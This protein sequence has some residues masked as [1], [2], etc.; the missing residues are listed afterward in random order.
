MPDDDDAFARCRDVL[1][2]NFSIVTPRGEALSCDDVLS[3]IRK[4]HDADAGR[5]WIEAPTLL[6]KTAAIVT[7]RY[8]EWHQQGGDPEGRLST[9]VFARDEATPNG[10]RWMTVHETWLGASDRLVRR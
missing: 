10:L 3:G 9:V 4:R 5:I 2:P 1:D 6:L 7:A 8:E